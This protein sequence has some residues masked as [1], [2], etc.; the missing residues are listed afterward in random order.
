MLTRMD[1][2]TFNTFELNDVTGRRPLSTL[3][4]LLMRQSGIITSLKLEEAKLTRSGKDGA[5]PPLR[6]ELNM[7]CG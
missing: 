5:M 7:A 1:N 4:F 6:S 2:W 3:A